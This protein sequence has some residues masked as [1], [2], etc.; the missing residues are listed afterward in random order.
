M[1]DEGEQMEVEKK[2]EPSDEQE[3]NSEEEGGSDDDELMDDENADGMEKL[4][5]DFEAFP[6]EDGDLDGIVNMASQMFLRADV[7][8]ESL[9]KKVIDQSPFGCVF[10]PA[11]ED[12]DEDNDNEVYGLLSIVD[13]VGKE[14]FQ[15]DMWNLLLQRAR[16]FADKQL[17]K[18]VEEKATK[19][20]QSEGSSDGK[21]G[22]LIN[23]RMLHF[24]AQIAGPA[25]KSLCEEIESLPEAKKYSHLMVIVKLRFSDTEGPAGAKPASATGSKKKMGKAE[26]KRQATAKLAESDIIYDN[27]EEAL[28]FQ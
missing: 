26:K 14:K 15:T 9:A 27:P 19:T 8:A 13:A 7:D 25:F 21:L 1:T 18:L 3:P 16:K 22:L 28:L 24:P 23:E 17:V 11:E 6:P 2:Q 20:N 12:V 10:R 4:N 5:F